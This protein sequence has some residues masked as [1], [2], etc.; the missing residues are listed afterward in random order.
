MRSIVVSILVMLLVI[1]PATE[2]LAQA[3]SHIGIGTTL[4]VTGGFSAEWGPRFLEFM[5]AWEKITNEEGGIFVKEFGKRIPVKLII[6][7][8]ESLADKSV[9][10]YEKLAGVDKV[11]IFLGPSTSPI[12]MRATTVAERLQ[13]PM[14]MAEANDEAVFSRGFRWSV[15]VQ[16]M[17]AP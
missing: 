14:V 1:M 10:L 8:D 13:I 16:G 9:E 2:A 3:P 5:K 12:T 4:P 17:G 11:H 6:Y 7:D 15:A